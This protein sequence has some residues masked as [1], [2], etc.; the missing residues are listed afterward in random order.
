MIQP[1][2][3]IPRPL[4]DFRPHVFVDGIAGHFEGQQWAT[5][6]VADVFKREQRRSW[7]GSR[8]DRDPFEKRGRYVLAANRPGRGTGKRS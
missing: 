4:R 6:F 7:L 1:A 8:L 2:D 5:N 3:I